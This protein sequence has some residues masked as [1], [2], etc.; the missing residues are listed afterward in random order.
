MGQIIGEGMT[1][2]GAKGAGWMNKVRTLNEFMKIDA[3][4]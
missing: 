1:T 4:G 3:H 2:S